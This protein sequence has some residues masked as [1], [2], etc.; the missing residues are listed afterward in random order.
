MLQ[1]YT[2]TAA[3]RHAT[4]CRYCRRRSDA[5]KTSAANKAVIAGVVG[6]ASPAALALGG[7]P[8]GGILLGVVLS[9]FFPV[10]G[11]A[12]PCSPGSRP[13]SQIPV[14]TVCIHTYDDTP[15]AQL[16]HRHGQ[17]TPI[18]R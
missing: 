17:L 18:C 1:K 7:Q 16:G 6:C 3:S 14:M 13:S 12:M 4:A 2:C 5:Q 15:P 10:R 9:C 8:A 11:A